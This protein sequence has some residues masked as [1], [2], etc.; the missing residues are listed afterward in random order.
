MKIAGGHQGQNGSISTHDGH[1]TVPR[2]TRKSVH[3]RSIW[4]RLAVL[5]AVVAIA[6]GVG[7]QS[8]LAT[9]AADAR[10]IQQEA[11]AAD[12]IEAAERVAIKNAVVEGPV[13]AIVLGV[14]VR[15]L[16]PIPAMS[17]SEVSFAV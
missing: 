15:N 11:D 5:V 9:S 4:P 13:I 7:L 8:H 3:K 10:A 16:C 14:V 2:P 12:D 17:V 6:A 1:A